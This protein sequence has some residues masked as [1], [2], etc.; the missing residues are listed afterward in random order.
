MILCARTQSVA[1]YSGHSGQ[2]EAPLSLE[3]LYRIASEWL[4]LFTTARHNLS[5]RQFKNREF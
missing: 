5:R 2:V 3:W 4:L 1:F